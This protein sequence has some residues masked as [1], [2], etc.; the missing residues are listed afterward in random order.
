MGAHI[1]IRPNRFE[2]M[3]GNK[4]QRSYYVLS[5]NPAISSP[6]LSLNLPLP[7]NLGQVPMV[8]TLAYHRADRIVM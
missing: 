8:L 2:G 7:A 1:S 4:G 3:R 6:E 5:L